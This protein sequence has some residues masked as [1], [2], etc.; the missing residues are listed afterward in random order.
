[1]KGLKYL[2]SMIL[3]LAAFQ[4]VGQT[5]V[6]DQV[7]VGSSRKYRVEGELNSNY[8]WLL[9]DASKL[10]VPIPN[11]SGT[12][13]IKT[14]PMVYGNEISIDW[15]KAGTFTLSVVETSQMGCDTME[16]G[17]VEVYELPTVVAGNPLI[18][19]SDAKV[20]LSTAFAS[21][22][23]SLLWSSSGDGKFDNPT[24]LHTFY[25]N[26]IND[27]IKG[28]VNLT[29][30]AEGMG[31]LPTCNPASSILAVTLNVV[32]DLVINDPPEICLPATIDLSA[33]SITAGSEPMTF[34]YFADSLA[35]IKLINY[36]SVDKSGTYYIRG[37]STTSGCEVYKPVK[38][39]FTKQII[40]SFAHI[41]E[42]CLNSTSPPVLQPSDFQGI[43]GTWSP[44][45]VETNTPGI[46]PYKFT[47][48][49]TPGICVKDTTIWIEVSNS[50]TPAFS[51][52]PSLCQGDLAPALS[53]VSDNG[54]SGS[55]SPNVINTSFTG[56][57]TYVFTPD[58]GQCGISV[59]K[60][61]TITPA[62]SPPTFTFPQICV[63]SVPP[64]LPNVS[65][66][67]VSGTWNPA[68]IST[69]TIG[70]KN[71]TFT[72]SS[73][74]CRQFKVQ[75]IEVIDKTDP[76]FNQIGPLCY[77]STPVVLP[78]T[79]QNGIPGTWT[80][81]VVN[82]NLDGMFTFT[83]VPA[84]NWCATSTTMTVEI[85]K[86]INLTITAAP[87]LI[88]GGTTNV[89]VS[90]TGGSGI[91]SGVGTFVRSAGTWNFTVADD[92]GCT[93][94]AGIIIQNPQDLIVT[95]VIKPML[96][97][98][99][100][101]EVAISVAGG[102]APYTY[103]YTGGDPSHIHFNSTTFLIKASP[104]P[105]VF[106]VTD[107]N[108][109][110]GESIPVIITNPPVLSL[111][112]SMTPPTC[113]GG[114]DGTATVTA[115][116]QVGTVSYQWDDPKKQTTA[117]ATG[118]LAGKYTVTVTDGCGPKTI[119]IMVTEPPAIIL[120][121]VG[122]PSQ[123]PGA[124]GII[125]FTITNIPDGNYNVTHTSGQFSSVQFSGGKASAPAAPGDYTNLKIA[126]NGCT[127][128]NGVN[129]SVS[130]ATVQPISFFVVQPTC[131]APFG[132]VFVTNPREGTGFEYSVDNGIFRTTANLL[133]LTAGKHKIHVR[134]Q[135]TSCVT[136]TV[137]TI[138]VLPITPANL[139]AIPLPVECETNPVQLL[140]ANNGIVAPPAGTSVIWYDAAGKVVL[141][142]TL[143]APGTVTYYAEATNGT[144]ASPDRTP[145]TLTIIKKPVAPASKGDI[146]VCETTPIQTLN[147][148]DAILATSG[149][150]IVW[151][152][153][154]IGGNI[155]ASPTLSSVKTVT[156]Y[157]VDFNG[158]CNSAPR[159]A[160][161]LTINRVPALLVSTV[162][163][164]E[165]E[166]SPLQTLNA[167]S[168]IKMIPGI[169]PVWYDAPT[170][171][172]TVQPIIN[173]VGSKT[174]YVES[175]NGDCI[176]VGRTPVT[177]TINKKPDAPIS[178]G[179]ITVC[180]TTPIQVLN[181]KDA[182]QVNP[183]Q[184]I[185]WYDR[186]TGGNVVASPTLSSVGTVTYYAVDF[187]GL[188]YSAPRT[189][190]ILTINP[191]PVKPKVGISVIPTCVV[192]TGTVAV[193]SPLGSELAYS[194]DNGGYQTSATF[195][196]LIPGSHF[197][198]VKNTVTGCESD[199]TIFKVP[200]VPLKPHIINVTSQNCIC[201]GDSGAINFEFR[202]VADGMYVI[203]YLGG[204]F[205]NVQVKNSKA[206][207]IAPAGNYNVLAIEANGCTSDESWNVSITQ[208]DPIS[209]S[210]K[211]TEIDLKSGQKG[212]INITITGGSGKYTTI[213]QPNLLS[214]FAG[215]SSED[216]NN[217]NDGNYTAII[218]DE[219]NCPLLYVGTIPVANQPPVATNDEFTAKCS[220]ISGDLIHT[221]NGNGVDSDPDGDLLTIDT[222]PV[223]L[224][225]HGVLTINSDGTF[226]Y[227]AYPGYTG[228]DT[229]RY[230]IY[231]IKQNYS[232][233]ATVTIH[234]IEDF[235]CDGIPD[236][237]D[238]DADGDG[239][240]NINEGGLT[241]DSDGD[242]HPNWLDI[243]A[244]NDGIV[245]NIEG[246]PTSGYIPP[247]GIDTNHDGIDD[248]YDPVNGGIR[249]IPVDTDSDGIPDF[250][251]ADSD[252]D[253]VP[254][255]IE[256]HDL[257]ADGKIDT[258]HK[259]TGKDTD[260][261]GLDDAWDT[262]IR[263]E[264]PI[265][266]ITGSNAPLQDFDG[267]GIKDWR[268]ENDDDDQYLTRFEDL[269]MDGNFANDDTDNDGHP[270]YLDY[271]RDCDLFI[272]NAFSPNDDNI[273]DYFQ[274]YCID[275][276]PDAKMYIFDQLG[277]QLYEKENYGNLQRWGTPEQAWWDGRTRNRNVAVTTGGKVVPGTYFY[278]LKLGNGEVRKSFVFV[279][280]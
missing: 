150:N 175:W 166:E 88:F 275:H 57:T 97:V 185:I 277:N 225:L 239:I 208:P 182:I 195:G 14:G 273:H 269:N 140:N 138:D 19:C 155:V 20:I 115:I 136:D 177:L 128:A 129:T 82:T 200:D 107:S 96:C 2:V 101:A 247:K 1:M 61:I 264:D 84:P 253:G 261:D 272:P 221:D 69:A 30:V 47:P 202:N 259:I 165:C 95:T 51:L 224:P 131:K 180:K 237:M 143:N 28:S 279:S 159:T 263:Y 53:L 75:A 34:E 154:A 179:D 260:S 49:P 234:I 110:H 63:G 134:K 262:V 105:Y 86:E 163:L 258:G 15:N 173:Q 59:S 231:D 78:V 106:V 176:S 268:D 244:D 183:G 266:N 158:V 12:P 137:T 104:I 232:N 66:D 11:P 151:Y 218:T 139:T 130:K 223:R 135:S 217:L 76:V 74:Q 67:G 152:D 147:A 10:K 254:D 245:D 38:V 174:F 170:G 80:P 229:F 90:A 13:F 94:T 133:G 189:S 21:N 228:D 42:V 227:L 212:E 172:S 9:T 196:N 124:D 188:C 4:V 171:G 68:F 257:D 201:Y 190:V 32:P 109:L 123:C 22:Y 267:D 102:T 89:T 216:L 169:T 274:I 203:V 276:F 64:P 87:I 199:T 24:A 116:N 98:G 43:G 236:N 83:F 52:P 5:Y 122:I 146:T 255:Y 126:Y 18:I 23:S 194:V 149:Q 181:A 241:A 79:S 233:P 100:Y 251:D 242:G 35:K 111:S 187:N 243:D 27:I 249:L 44:A 240:L 17:E 3:L 39:K 215:A 73:G 191:L 192:P 117:K 206:K 26:G 99:G 184:N 7:C 197:V 148:N 248:A 246:Q 8:Q 71:Y 210:A 48:D 54:I 85:Y 120:T 193:L 220:A 62:G 36:K 160:V 230:R 235:D 29:L 161:K 46:F 207:I 278:V 178:K 16:Q 142:P 270:E 204:K 211:I 226:K 132:S 50:I 157:A 114:S 125:Q 250:L 56:P 70:I 265:A 40:P 156:F 45:V 33:A 162:P 167:N 119:N 72:P 141:Q 112:A 256:G 168:Y 92:K 65:D 113:F 77:N 103:D 219:N 145:V 121:A 6:I 144:C 198:K 37:T 108:G 214:G 186:I 60:V 25:S 271:G 31:K 238:Q 41:S 213:W 209:V 118:L 164:P 58:A 205:E 81:S 93:G 91:Y 252:N 222:T 55:W 280:Y 127:S 153:Q